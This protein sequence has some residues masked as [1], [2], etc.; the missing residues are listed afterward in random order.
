MNVFYNA[1]TET[2]DE[3]PNSA[4]KIYVHICVVTVFHCPIFIKQKEVK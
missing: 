3:Q 2:V 1:E 4:I